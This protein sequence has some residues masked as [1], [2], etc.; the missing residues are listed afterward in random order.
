[1]YL[2]VADTGQSKCK[3]N[4]IVLVANVFSLIQV[5]DKSDSTR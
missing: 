5:T 3:F 1:M 2:D 4:Y